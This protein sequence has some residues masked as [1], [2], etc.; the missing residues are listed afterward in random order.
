M[1][2]FSTLRR[3]AAEEERG[4]KARLLLVLANINEER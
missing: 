3:T 4:G 2:P 1:R